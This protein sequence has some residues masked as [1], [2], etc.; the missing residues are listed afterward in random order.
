MKEIPSFETSIRIDH[1]TRRHVQKGRNLNYECFIIYWLQLPYQCFYWKMNLHEIKQESSIAKVILHAAET[2]YEGQK[3][4][5]VIL[6]QLFVIKLGCIILNLSSFRSVY[7]WE[8]RMTCVSSVMLFSYVYVRRFYI[9]RYDAFRNVIRH[10]L[11]PNFMHTWDPKLYNLTRQQSI[12][13]L[14]HINMRVQW[15]FHESF[16]FHSHTK[17]LKKV[18]SCS[19]QMYVSTILY[20]TVLHS[21]RLVAASFCCPVAARELYSIISIYFQLRIVVFSHLQTCMYV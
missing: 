4:I 14:W 19:E 15:N 10:K 12:L 21:S 1:T 18:P 11:L 20:V 3:Q 7:V 5:T 17:L 6:W 2:V 16:F 8:Q 9:S 13:Q